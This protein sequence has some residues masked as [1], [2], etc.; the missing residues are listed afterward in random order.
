M[1][2]QELKYH[3]YKFQRASSPEIAPERWKPI[4]GHDV[5]WMEE[6][7]QKEVKEVETTEQKESV[8]A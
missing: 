2:T 5:D 3:A 8:E 1:L 4:F 7:Y 6:K